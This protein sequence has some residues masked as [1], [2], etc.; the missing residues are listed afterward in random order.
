MPFVCFTVTN[1]RT[2][3][4]TILTVTFW[5]HRPLTVDEF[6]PRT[7]HIARGEH[8]WTLSLSS[9]YWMGKV[10]PGSY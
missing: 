1:M 2:G 4:D 6:C 7:L 10:T 3:G 5:L 8:R 9:V